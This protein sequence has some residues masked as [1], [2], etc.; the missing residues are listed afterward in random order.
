MSTRQKEGF[1]VQVSGVRVQPHLWPKERPVWSKR[2]LTNVQH[3]KFDVGRWA[4]DVKYFHVLSHLN[5][6]TR[7]SR[8]WFWNSA[9]NRFWI[10][11]P[12]FNPS[13]SVFQH[14]VTPILHITF[15]MWSGHRFRGSNWLCG[16]REVDC[17]PGIFRRGGLPGP[18]T[19][20]RCM[21][22]FAYR[23]RLFLVWKSFLESKLRLKSQLQCRPT[24][25]Y[26]EGYIQQISSCLTSFIPL[27]IKF[28]CHLPV[29]AVQKGLSVKY[30]LF[31]RK[32]EGI[33]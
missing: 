2:K 20:S 26:P 24:S 29:D 27:N 30:R 5:F 21:L 7:S 16:H 8:I 12:K 32:N 28:Y 14:S 6:H 33:A 22:Q 31:L 19:R 4:L 17:S 23:D 10:N 3:W 25:I 1:S 15:F 13:Y 9:A 18:A 11:K